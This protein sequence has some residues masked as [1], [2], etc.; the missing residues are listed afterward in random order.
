M[1][2]LRRLGGAVILLL[3]AVSIIGCVAGIFSIW[4][5]YQRVSEKVQTISARLDDGLQRVSTA[6]HNV[7]L[8]LEKARGDVDNVGKQTS[9]LGDSGE[10]SRRASRTLRALVHQKA[11]PNIDELHGRL[12]TLSDTAVAVSSLLKS[13]QEVSSE[14]SLHV[15]PD[16]L[17]HR[18]EE[19][20][21]LS[22]TLRRLEVVVGDGDK[23]TSG[24]EV[25]ATTNAVDRVLERCQTTVDDWQSELDAVRADL[26]PVKTQT[27]RWLLI[28]AIA[29]TVLL[30]WV[31]AG[32]IS[33]FGRAVAWLK[34][35]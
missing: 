18:A 9:D 34:C 32:Q 13:F 15:N 17:K 10:K 14:R 22:A 11:G 25:V 27:L 29:M 35:A 23:E 2:F 24:Q 33:L 31:A 7:Q 19:A 12:A 3:C 26:E 4:I 28:G 16:Q 20:Q 8:A 1:R 6:T 5:F 30:V 21:H